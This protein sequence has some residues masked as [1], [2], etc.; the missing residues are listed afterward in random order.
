MANEAGAAHD[1]DSCAKGK[2]VGPRGTFLPRAF[3]AE[4]I[5]DLPSR[6]SCASDL[7]GAPQPFKPNR[8]RAEKL[9][10]EGGYELG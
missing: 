4:N 8:Q 5:A 7:T 1:R 3:K 6:E 10:S 2:G 9:I